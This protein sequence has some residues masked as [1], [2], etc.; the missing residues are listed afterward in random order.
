MHLFFRFGRS[1]SSVGKDMISLSLMP[2]QGKK[3]DFFGREIFLQVLGLQ[4][5]SIDA[6]SRASTNRQQAIDKGQK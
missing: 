5:G 1:I 2:F 4:E 3:E 6:F